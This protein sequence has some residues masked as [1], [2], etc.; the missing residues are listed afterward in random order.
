[1]I[2]DEG[3]EFSR[4][5]GPFCKGMEICSE[6][7]QDESGVVLGWYGLIWL[8]MTVGSDARVNERERYAM[9]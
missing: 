3:R 1:M 6:R 5:M 7:E 8:C 9:V 4:D 2:Y